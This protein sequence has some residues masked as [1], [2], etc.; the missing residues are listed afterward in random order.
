MVRPSSAALC[1]LC[2]TPSR[3]SRM[4]AVL[5]LCSAFWTGY[6]TSRPALKRYVRQTSS[7]LQVSRH[8]EAWT[9]GNG[10]TTQ[11]LW[12]AQGVAQHHDGVSGTAKQAVTYDYA[13]RLSVGY[14][15]AANYLTQAVAMIITSGRPSTDVHHLSAPQHLTVC[16]VTVEPEAG[17]VHIQPSTHPRTQRIAIPIAGS[18][19]GLTVLNS[20]GQA[21][22]FQQQATMPN[23]ARGS[24]SAAAEVQFIANIP[25]VGFATY[26]VVP[27]SAPATT[28]SPLLA[29]FKRDILPA[30]SRLS[31]LAREMA[32]AAAMAP[33]D[34]TISND[35]WTLT[36]DA[37]TASLAVLPIERPATLS[38]SVSSS[39]T[40]NRS[41]RADRTVARTSSVLISPMRLPYPSL[42]E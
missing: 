3:C 15:I 17:T 28:S 21:V 42:K 12:E 30:S 33:A 40:T 19:T 18:S 1:V 2:G 32:A 29:A 13:Q 5:W 26:F 35:Y 4:C 37:A 11:A 16:H 39:C 20:T 41:N 34:T 38:P 6:F 9:G 7:F 27:A 25:P 14:D 36:F 8:W 10:S 31:W 22:P 24:D 23:I